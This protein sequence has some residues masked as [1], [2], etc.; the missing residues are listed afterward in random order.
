[1]S[2]LRL[3]AQVA[4][5]DLELEVN[6][7]RGAV[8]AVLG[9]NGAGKSTLLSLVAGLLRP[10]AGRIELNGRVLTDTTKGIAVPPHRREVALLSQQPLLFPHLSAAQNVAFGPR[11]AGVG[12]RAA[13]AEALRWLDAVGARD[14]AD[15]RPHQLSGGQAQRVAVARA[16][17][18][19]PELLLLDEPMAALDVGAAPAVR[20]LLRRILR[21]GDRTAVL[22]THD[23]LDA[24]ALADRVVVVE[25][26]RVVEE[27]AAH[28]VLAHP[29]GVFAARLAGVNLIA[30]QATAEGL[31]TDAGPVYGVPDPDCVAG[32]AAVAVFAPTAVAVFR[33]EPEG[34]PRN[35]FRVTVSEMEARGRVV[36]IKAADHPDGTTGLVA[37]ITAASTAELEL[38]PGVEVY[39]VV[40][41]TEV[42]VHEA[43]SPAV[44]LS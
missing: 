23:L 17:A 3:K 19:A 39:F 22:V 13:Q 16:L 37:D 6:V 32:E 11:S 20:A 1:M 2:G 5:R 43:A 25:G 12:R 42:A 44:R 26:G 34:S 18:A 33:V 35:V 38:E 7:E 27:G 9:P 24:L 36:R 41:A 29:R 21:T 40:K 8:L 10:D 15:R 31:R 14:L 30:G 4:A 28:Q